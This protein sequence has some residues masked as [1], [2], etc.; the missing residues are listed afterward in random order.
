MR[1]LFVEN[2]EPFA[3]PVTDALVAAG[4][5]VDRARSLA[6]ARDAAP[7]APYAAILLDRRLPDGDG[8]DLCRTLRA[9]GSE[10]P[11]LL[12]TA[13]D[14]LAD[15]VEGLDAGADDYLVKPFAFDELAARLRAVTRRR[16]A[17]RTNVWTR[18]AVSV[19]LAAG[20]A[21]VGDHALALTPKEFVLLGTFLRSSGG[22]LSHV[23]LLDLAWD[24]EADP[25]PEVVRRT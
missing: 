3:R 21:R 7:G 20:V 10:V 15:R 2:V 12:L 23:H 17:Q 11:I 16:T 24:G 22:V 18:G 13:R 8:L 19:D 25:N 6:D 14:T 5:L 9:R 4:Y 1:L